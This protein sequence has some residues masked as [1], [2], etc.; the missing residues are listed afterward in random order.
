MVQRL[1]EAARRLL[2]RAE[3]HGPPAASFDDPQFSL[4]DAGAGTVKALVA[5][6]GERGLEVLSYSA[7]P[8]G[9]NLTAAAEQ[10]LVAAEDAAG[11]VP[12]RVVVTVPGSACTLGTGTA[13]ARRSQPLAPVA[14]EEV[15]TLVRRAEEAA[16]TAAKRLAAAERGGGE[17]LQQVHRALVEVLVDGRTSLA[18]PGR[19]GQHVQARVVVV[20][21]A[22]V[23]LKAAAE[24][25]SVLD[26]EL[27][28]MVA[29]PFALGSA[30]RGRDDGPAL[31]VD[32]GAIGTGIVLA[33]A[34]GAEAAAWIPIGGAALEQR[35][36]ERLGIDA[37][38]ASDGV[39][40]HSAG[41]GHRSSAGPGA[42]RFIAQVAQHHAEVW[43]DAFEAACAELGRGRTLPARVLLC[44]GGAALPDVRRA[45]GGSAWHAALSFERPPAVRPLM[46]LDLADVTL[47]EGFEGGTE[48]VPALC[49]TAAYVRQGL[50]QQET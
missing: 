36:Q 37:A 26:L 11:V 49:A 20:S 43:L 12:R 9:A 8:A 38:R 30:V 35:L 46:P 33:G 25:A 44:G 17:A 31:V 1:G 50:E 40:A 23:A 27:A 10:A 34:L 18:T 39:M 16:L 47:P 45:L 29:A 42:G 19:A 3:Q 24:T 48:A 13:D 5:Q 7:V 41:A 22:A 14:Q 32:V 15:E 21:A 6:L 4:L 2:R 28:G